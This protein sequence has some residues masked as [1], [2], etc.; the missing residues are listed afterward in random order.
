MSFIE[1]AELFDREKMESILS[2]DKSCVDEQNAFGDTALHICIARED[3]VKFLLAANASPNVQNKV[4][5]TPLH[6]A[7]ALNLSRTVE[8][9][10]NAKAD[11]T[12]KNNSGFLPEAY[13]NY[14]AL[15]NTLVAGHKKET[16]IP[17]QQK[18]G[19][20]IGPKGATLQKLRA[21]S[22]A[23]IE[24]P[25][26]AMEPCANVIGRPENVAEAKRLILEILYPKKNRVINS[27]F[28]I[29][30][31]YLFILLG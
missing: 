23:Y 15:F 19:L 26:D 4:G 5:S 14:L 18:S 9:L 12:I 2:A 21:Q 6:R 28:F 16:T 24:V 1:A 11:P 13:T 20:I 8:K 27:S 17:L 30:Y 22:G 10:L 25:K 7:A 29:I 31:F 3:F